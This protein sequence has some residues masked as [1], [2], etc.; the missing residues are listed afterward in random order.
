MSA[1]NKANQ[2]GHNLNIGDL[3]LTHLYPPH[4]RR[5]MTMPSETKVM[6]KAKGRVDLIES[7]QEN[8]RHVRR[9]HKLKRYLRRV[10]S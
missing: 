10:N 7:M 2:M 6:L 5:P 3:P 4:T 9:Q 8:I 1:L